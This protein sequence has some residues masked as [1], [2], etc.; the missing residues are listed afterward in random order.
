MIEKL[1]GLQSV[2][3]PLYNSNDTN[4]SDKINYYIQQNFLG[5]KLHVNESLNSNMN[6]FNLVDLLDFT[7]TNFNKQIVLTPKKS[8]S[9]LTKWELKKLGE[10]TQLITKGTTPTSIGFDFVNIGINFIK[11]ESITKS[12]L[13]DQTKFAFINKQCDEK[14]SRSRLSENDILFSI[15]GAL[16]R[17]AIVNKNV[18]PANTNQ[19]LAIIRLNEKSIFIN[20]FIYLILTSDFIQ[21]QLD[22]LKIGIAQPNLSLAQINDFKIP[23]PPIEIQQQIV[24]ECNIIDDANEKAFNKIE[25]AKQKIEI[26]YNNLFNKSTKDFRLNNSELFDVSIGRRIL[27]KDV[28]SESS[29]AIPV[30]SANVFQE[31][32]Y[33]KKELLKDFSKPSIL[34]GIDGDWMVNTIPANKPFYPTDHCGVIR[35]KT[36]EIH[37]KYLAWVLHRE[38]EISR[39]SRANRASTDRVKGISF[40]APSINDQ[41]KSMNE[42]EKLEEIIAVEQEK[43]NNSMDKK[44]E[45]INK[46]L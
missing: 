24:D 4:D 2:N 16:G 21:N 40:K 28:T 14:M 17:S 15:A 42:V 30:F 1:Y 5:N 19:A 45:I 9:I 7:R 33:I 34:W 11:I 32:G 23:Y 13:F 44:K 12:G 41:K 31:F 35:I 6:Y 10:E 8:T 27:A 26:Y 25:K 37:H 29:D 22:G 20:K 43:I 38:G 46:Y 39:F 3:T 36:D 18:L